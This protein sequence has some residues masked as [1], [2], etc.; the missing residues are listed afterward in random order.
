[1]SGTEQP[2]LRGDA[3]W[4]AEVKEIAKRND[5][6]R[7]AGARRRAAKEAGIS[8]EAARLARSE[9][10]GRPVQPGR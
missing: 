6:A 2:R 4:R 1:M 5:E 9:Q 3:A 8:E 7:A 10:R